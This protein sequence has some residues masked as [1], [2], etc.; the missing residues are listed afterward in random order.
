MLQAIA[1]PILPIFAVL[2]AGFL[3]CRLSVFDAG[4]ATA[5]NRFV[6]Y[7][8]A[9]ALV[10]VIF[11]RAPLGNLNLPI[12]ASYFAAEFLIYCT[13]TWLA[14][15]VFRLAFAESL[16]LGM[17]AIFSNHVFFN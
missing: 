15:F 9:P 5:I 14:R 11:A 16:L 7:L 1:D 8:A 12:L 4:H 3:L 10:F 2:A 13:V 6:F 17:T